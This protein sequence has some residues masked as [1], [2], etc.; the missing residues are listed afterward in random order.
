M[1][2]ENTEKDFRYSPKLRK[3]ENHTVHYIVFKGIT[4]YFF[5]LPFILD[6]IVILSLKG[7]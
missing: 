3:P 2:L 6:S 1:L 7:C 4:Y 5:K